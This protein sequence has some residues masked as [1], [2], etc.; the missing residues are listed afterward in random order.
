MENQAY[1]LVKALKYFRVYGSHSHI[2]AYV[3][4][5]VIKVISTQADPDG[6]RS[7]WVATL[8]EYDLEIR[9]TKL[10]KGQGLENCMTPSNFDYLDINFVA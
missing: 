6:K 8:L 9:P 5:V 2:V 4:N 7:K 1:A 10:V 3:T